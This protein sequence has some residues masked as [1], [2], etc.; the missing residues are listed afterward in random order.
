[1]A[2]LSAMLELAP[3]LLRH[4]NVVVNALMMMVAK[5]PQMDV[6]SAMPELAPCLLRLL[7]VVVLARTMMVARAH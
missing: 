5:V 3:C 4:P 6:L 7:N 1:M 2:V